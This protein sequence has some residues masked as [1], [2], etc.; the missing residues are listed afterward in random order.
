MQAR[1]TARGLSGCKKFF[2]SCCLTRRS[3][4]PANPGVFLI[5]CNQPLNI[6]KHFIFFAFKHQI[7]LP[8]PAQPSTWQLKKRSKHLVTTVTAVLKCG[9]WIARGAVHSKDR[10]HLA[11]NARLRIPVNRRSRKLELGGRW[12]CSFLRESRKVTRVPVLLCHRSI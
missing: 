10:K 3:C 1:S 8:F 2:T 11:M 5:I 12:P 9:A 4:C 7:P 6:N